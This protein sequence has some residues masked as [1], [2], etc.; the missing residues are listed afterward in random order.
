M[1]VTVDISFYPLQDDYV[2]RVL[3]FIEQLRKR[4]DLTI[5][6]NA[7]STQITG[8]YEEVMSLVQ[9][10]M[11][12]VFEFEDAVFVMKVAKTVRS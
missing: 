8:P 2:R 9:E 1:I 3:S 10:Q 4:T 5:Q 7:M 12:D 6:T 11:Q